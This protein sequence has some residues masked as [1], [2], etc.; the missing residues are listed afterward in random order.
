M[1]APDF[2]LNICDRWHKVLTAAGRCFAVCIFGLAG[3]TVLICMPHVLIE[4]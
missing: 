3:H 2:W 4:L 1:V